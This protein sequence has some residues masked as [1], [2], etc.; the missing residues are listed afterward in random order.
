MYCIQSEVLLVSCIYLCEGSHHEVI[1]HDPTINLELKKIG[2]K[3][4]FVLFHKSGVTDDLYEYISISMQSGIGISDI[5]RLLINLHNAH[6]LRKC[7][8]FGHSP[9]SLE[10]TK[11]FPGRKLITRIFLRSFLETEEMYWQHTSEKQGD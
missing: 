11:R 10:V 6:H 7:S 1:A 3:L 9:V 5:E 8:Y 4:P 2:I